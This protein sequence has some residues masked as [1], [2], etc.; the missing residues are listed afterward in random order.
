MICRRFVTLSLLS[1]SF[2]LILNQDFVGC[3]LMIIVPT[4]CAP[5][6]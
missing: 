3:L 2:S 5:S 1:Y 6:E 4:Y